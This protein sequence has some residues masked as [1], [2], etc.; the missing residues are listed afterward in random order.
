[1]PRW[2]NDADAPGLVLASAVDPAWQRL[3]HLLN[4]APSGVAFT[5]AHRGEPLLAGRRIR[6]DGR[7]GLM[8]PVGVRLTLT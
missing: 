5:L 4:V 2:R 3:L 1:M 8:L 6:V 7:T